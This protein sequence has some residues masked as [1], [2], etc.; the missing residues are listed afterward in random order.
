M[1]ITEELPASSASAGPPEMRHVPQLIIAR[2]TPQNLERGVLWFSE[3]AGELL[4]AARTHA[5][6]RNNLL[7]IEEGLIIR[8]SELARNLLDFGYERA[9]TALGRGL[10]AHRGGIVEVWPINIDRAYAIEFEGNSIVAIHLGEMREE[11]KISPRRLSQEGVS[12]LPEGGFAVHEDHGIGIFRGADTAREFFIIEYAPPREGGEPD[13]LLVPFAQESRLA[14][15]VGFE[16]PRVHRLG[17]NV[18]EHT[19]QKVREETEKLASELLSLYAR[20][21]EARRLPQR[22]DSVI[23]EEI[24]ARFPFKETEDQLTA[25]QEIMADLE[26]P[27]PMD[28]ILCGDVGFGKTELAMR[29]AARAVASGSQVA[30]LAPTTILV[31]QHEETFTKR[32]AGLP[33]VVRALSRLTPPR[34]RGRIE[35][36]I[37]EGKADIIIGTHRIL[38]SH[39]LFKNL[40]LA[41]IDEEQ[42]FGVKQKEKF[43]N[44]RAHI[45]MLSLSATPIP[46]TLQFTLARLREISL[47]STPPADRVPIQTF[48]V[49]YS[50]HLIRE[51]VRAELA[52]GGQVY[53]LHNRVET[54]GRAKEK[55]EKILQSI[56]LSSSSPLFSSPK[57]G[58]I[59]GRMPEHELVRTMHH[60]RTGDLNILL[61]T[62]IIENGLDI[63]SANT[64]IVEDATRLGLAQAHQLRGRIGRGNAAASAYFLFRS[65]NLT[66]KS[67]DRLEALQEYAALGAGY[68][69]ALRDLEIRGA[70]NILGREQSGAAYKV[71]LNLYYQMLAEAVESMKSK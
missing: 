28:R 1:A 45:D 31:S 66:D 48:V 17:G 42:R 34:D 12:S 30:V 43:K 49:P 41:I 24:R 16:N 56:Q 27:K 68:A 40:G 6:W 70:G 64:L 32:F 62:T 46:R 63:S 21:E 14:P 60:F 54:I 22:G 20:R 2:V 47:L 9:R 67:R 35:K 7:V 26:A 58:I 19:K 50:T 33:I 4:R 11:R 8:P 15:Y 5:W 10:Y 59:H 38:S 57:I 3:H 65:K 36:E 29:A 37:A 52:R 18:W 69:L 61:A 39:I 53:I 25:E 44:L 13:R 55:L 71:G 23:E 51:A